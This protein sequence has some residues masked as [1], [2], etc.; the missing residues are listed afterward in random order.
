MNDEQGPVLAAVEPS[1]RPGPELAVSYLLVEFD[2]AWRHLGGLEDK[3]LKLFLGYFVGA[4]LILFGTLFLLTIRSWAASATGLHLRV[5]P[6]AWLLLLS[7]AFRYIALSERQATERYR[8]KINLVRRT[9][10]EILSSTRLDAMQR[11]GNDL[12]LQ[13]SATLEK[14]LRTVDILYQHR[15]TTALFMKLTY[16][17]GALMGILAVLD[18]I[19]A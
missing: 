13:I 10:L 16:D 2:T 14:N 5:V 19:R 9:L 7:L 3:R 18:A 17:L 11:E 8:K 6:G 1:V 12:G 15:W 4:T